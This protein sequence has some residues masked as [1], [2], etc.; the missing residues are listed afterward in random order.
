LLLSQLYSLLDRIHVHLDVFAYNSHPR[1]SYPLIDTIRLFGFLRASPYGA[2]KTG[3][4]RSVN[5]LKNL[6]S[7]KKNRVQ[8]SI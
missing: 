4:I 3:S 6:K 1:S 5:I 2:A 7:N 8:I